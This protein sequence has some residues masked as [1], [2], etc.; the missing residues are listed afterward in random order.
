MMYETYYLDSGNL[1]VRY[2]T[3]VNAVDTFKAGDPL[4][5]LSR[6]ASKIELYINDQTVSSVGGKL[7]FEDGKVSID[8]SGVTGLIA[9]R[10][11]DVSMRVW[12]SLHATKGQIFCH[13]D[14][15][16][17]RFKVNVSKS[18]V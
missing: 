3:F 2:F 7:T 5:F 17:S 16:Q 13:P 1:I 4:P 6:K 11:Y 18:E 10:S 14:M 12:D 15:P 8:L 9:S